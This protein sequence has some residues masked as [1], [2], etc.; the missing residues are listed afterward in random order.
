MEPSPAKNTG[1]W[2]GLIAG[3]VI[4][5][6]TLCLYLGGVEYMLGGLAWLGNVL[7]LVIA[8]LAG[9]RQKK[10]NGGFLTF[11]DA[12]KTV[13]MVFV[14]C[15][16]LQT[17]FSYI[18]FNYIDTPFRDAYNQ[19]LLE[20]SASWMKSMG[21]SEDDIEKMMAEGAN[22]NNYSIR[23]MLLGFGFWCIACFIISLIIAAIIKK[24]RPPFEN[25]INK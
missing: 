9:L 20:K 23:N 12:L 17:I 18:L 13:F 1:L 24:N 16:L 21:M 11:G 15:F 8:V 6:Y 25:S 10:A 22:K 2:F 19:A 7:I 5:V 4:I 3:L 14:V